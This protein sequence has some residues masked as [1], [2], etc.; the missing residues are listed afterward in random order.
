MGEEAGAGYNE[1]QFN[2]S[3]DAMLKIMKGLVASNIWRTNEYFMIV[4]EGDAVIA[5][6]LKVVSTRQT[7]N[8]LLGYK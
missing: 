5:N 2:I 4:N 7:Y 3:R 8:K 1:S 6:A